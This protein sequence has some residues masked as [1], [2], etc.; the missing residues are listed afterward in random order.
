[1]QRSLTLLGLVCLISG[2]Q[3]ASVSISEEDRISGG[4]AASIKEF[5]FMGSIYYNGTFNCSGTLYESKYVIT[6]AHCVDKAIASKIVVY[7]NSATIAPAKG[8]IMRTVKS[9]K[10]HPDFS[11][12]NTRPINDIA[13]LVLSS[14]VTTV[15]SVTLGDAKTDASATILGWGLTKPGEKLIDSKT[16]QKA[17]VTVLDNIVCASRLKGYWWCG[18]KWWSNGY[19]YGCAW[20]RSAA[21]DDRQ[22]NSSL[23]S[24]QVCAAA[25]GVNT[26]TGDDG[27][28]LL[29]G[30][31]QV[32][33]VS[34]VQGE[35]TGKEQP[36]VN[37][38]L[39]E[40]K[41]WID[42]STP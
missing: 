10:L 34:L 36:V 40:Y 6:A 13:I 9:V 37:T 39:S 22:Q 38:R 12:K 2:A 35:C 32:G 14:P 5:S 3:L 30:K 18:Y 20:T 4:A 33:I 27:G 41:N 16:L 24:T 19:A 29:V 17:S 26:C 11:R 28:P 42:Q 15:K 23:D 25:K 7:F 1:M 21:I 8:H 31:I